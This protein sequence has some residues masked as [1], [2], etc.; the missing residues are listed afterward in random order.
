MRWFW[1]YLY[2]RSNPANKYLLKSKIQT[3][4]KVGNM[5]K[6]NNKELTFNIF[7]TLL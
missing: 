6:V 1:L 7:H 5:F 3:L 4:E 2:I